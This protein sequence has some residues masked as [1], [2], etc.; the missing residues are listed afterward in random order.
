M[1]YLHGAFAY[2]IVIFLIICM[3]LFIQLMPED[4]KETKKKCVENFKPPTSDFLVFNYLPN[5]AIT[6]DVLEQKKSPKFTGLQG[7]AVAEG[8]MQSTPLTLVK[9]VEPSKASGIIKEK[10]NKYLQPGNILRFNIVKDG[11]TIPYTNY[12]IN[13]RQGERIKNLHVGMVTTRFMANT[14]DSLH[15]STTAANALQGSAWLIIHN[16]TNIPLELN[17][18]EIKVD[19]HSTYRYLGYLNQGVTLGTYFKDPSGLYPDFQYLQPHTDLY[20]GIVSDLQQPL[21]G[22]VQYDDFNDQCNYGD[23]LWPFQDGIY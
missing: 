1:D 21:M 10:A 23:T 22:C 6:V 3:I 16:T 5:H 19:P 2:A 15:V 20:Y 11:K 14:T 4:N 18:G 12:V 9:S 8:T 13:T 7:R 17:N